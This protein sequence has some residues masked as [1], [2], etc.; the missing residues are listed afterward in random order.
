MDKKFTMKEYVVLAALSLGLFFE[1][2]N[3]IFP[4]LMGQM[5]NPTAATFGF[6]LRE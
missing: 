2:G 6:S 5:A 4:A 3:L 1:A